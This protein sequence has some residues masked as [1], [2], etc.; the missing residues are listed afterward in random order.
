MTFDLQLTIVCDA[1]GVVTWAGAGHWPQGEAL[2]AAT[3]RWGLDGEAISEHWV[4]IRPQEGEPLPW[5]IELAIG[6]KT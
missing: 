4:T 2:A 5:H 1:D 3:E 6:E